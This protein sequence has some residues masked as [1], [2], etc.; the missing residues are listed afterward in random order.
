MAPSADEQPE[1]PD[2]KGVKPVV[3]DVTFTAM[4]PRNELA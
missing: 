1:L 3:E 2:H 4:I